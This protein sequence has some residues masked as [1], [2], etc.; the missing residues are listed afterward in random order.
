MSEGQ[1]VEDQW[2]SSIQP[3]NKSF[4]RGPWIIAGAIV[5]A[6][7]IVSVTLVVLHDDKTTLGVT[8]LGPGSSAY[9]EARARAQ[10]RAA[11][12]ELRNALVAAKVVY[13]D[14]RSYAGAD[15]SFSGL[16][17]VEPSLCYVDA[18]TA[19]TPDEFCSTISVYAS[20]DQWAAARMPDTGACFWIKDDAVTG[21]TYGF[22]E[23]C[24]GAAATRA[25]DES[26]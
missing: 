4:G 21:T 5:A 22:G 23:P 15:A 1:R 9:L 24:T 17:T 16:S 12:S 11:Q 14:S 3:G 6:A 19:S 18:E 26:W 13:T 25:S 7:A 2:S 20:A 8:G 10:D